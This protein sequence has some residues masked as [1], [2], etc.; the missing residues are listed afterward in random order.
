MN[1]RV[2]VPLR[3][4]LST[5]IRTPLDAYIYALTTWGIYLA[6]LGSLGI[7][8][9]STLSR[10]GLLW[11]AYWSI[12][13]LGYIHNDY[14]ARRREQR[15]GLQVK[16]ALLLPLSQQAI[17]CAIITRFSVMMAALW[18]LKGNGNGT[19]ILLLALLIAV[20]IVFFLHNLLLGKVRTISYFVLHS[21]RYLLLYVLRP[22][23]YGLLLALLLGI[24]ASVAMTYGYVQYK[25]YFRILSPPVTLSSRFRIMALMYLVEGL[26]CRLAPGSS[27]LAALC[28]WVAASCIVSDCFYVAVRIGQRLLV[29]LSTESIRYH[30]HTSFSHDGGW[31]VTELAATAKGSGVRTAYI[32]EHSEDMGRESFHA[33]AQECATASSRFGVQL[34]PGIEYAILEQH[35]LALGLREYLAVDDRR[36]GSLRS[37]RGHCSA[38]V[39]AHPR[40]QLRKIASGNILHVFDLLR[41]SIAVD[42]IEWLNLKPDKRSC[43]RWR[44]VLAL[45]V[46]MYL[47]G[48]EAY[49]GMDSHNLSHWQGSDRRLQEMQSVCK[50]LAR[51][52]RPIFGSPALARSKRPE[53]EAS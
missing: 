47:N 31:S 4:W 23:S 33:L 6:G 22:D 42:G 13:E 41:M 32:T 8:S 18:I 27:R 39:W 44:Y 5:R 36:L 52:L 3:Y 19:G 43:E 12:Y 45:C 53:Q 11:L 29:S 50:R 51:A 15:A 20:L 30:M 24:P 2:I 38:L 17:L 34:I 37:I 40:I 14:W 48:C 9:A 49:V 10:M 46:G 1:E 16:E 21:M 25:R 28:Y 7:W 35:F 26:V